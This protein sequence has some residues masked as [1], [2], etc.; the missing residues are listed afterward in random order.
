MPSETTSPSLS[1]EAAL[2]LLILPD[3]DGLSEDQ[4]RGTACVWTGEPL[5]TESA[6]DLGERHDADGVLWFPRSGRRGVT[7]A[8][9]LRLQHHSQMCEQCTDDYRGCETGQALVRLVRRYR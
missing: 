1:P 8:A 5:T 9:L 2:P 4:R 3:V 6:I 7:S